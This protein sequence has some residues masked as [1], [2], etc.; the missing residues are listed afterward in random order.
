MPQTTRYDPSS[1][2]CEPA[3]PFCAAAAR[4]SAVA[5]HGMVLA[6][7]DS[8]GVAPGHL[9]VIPRRHTADFFSMTDEERR[10]AVELLAI[11]RNRALKEDPTI[12]GINV[13]ANCGASAGQR[14]MHAHVHFI[15]RRDGDGPGG[16]GVKGVVR[17]KMAY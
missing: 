6:V 17:N 4:A 10:D 3:C 5:E 9:L 8:D 7:E 2:G 1:G 15:P 12:T 16:R 13:G 14:I 11:L